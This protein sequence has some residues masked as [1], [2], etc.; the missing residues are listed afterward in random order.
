MDLLSGLR[1]KV[2]SAI[3][4]GLSD[5]IAA[6]RELKLY[7]GPGD[8]GLLVSVSPLRTIGVALATD[9][10][11]AL[12]FDQRS[13]LFWS[14]FENVLTTEEADLVDFWQMFTLDEARQFFPDLVRHIPEHAPAAPREPILA[15]A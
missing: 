12:D 14:L 6:A 8:F 15:G 2:E 13:E 10:F 1:T 5:R 11:G 3:G 7:D 9:L 4:S